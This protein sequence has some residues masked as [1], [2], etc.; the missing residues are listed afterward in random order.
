MVR[1][2]ASA[3]YLL[4]S[5]APESLS[6]KVAPWPDLS[7][8]TLAFLFV[9]REEARILQIENLPP[10]EQLRGGIRLRFQASDVAA[11]GS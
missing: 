5:A 10:S 6:N 1:N 11:A 9:D 2:S 3:T 4:K 7:E 8:E